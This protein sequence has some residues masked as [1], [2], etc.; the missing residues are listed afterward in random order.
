[1][2]VRRLART[3]TRPASPPEP[4]EPPAPPAS[5]TPDRH[6]RELAHRRNDG[7]DVAL[8]WHPR[9]DAVTVAVA[10]SRTGRDIEFPVDPARALDAF[11]HPFAYAR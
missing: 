6:A 3:G 5:A 7:L 9:D 8:L 4:P 1:M 10:D 11:R 2:R